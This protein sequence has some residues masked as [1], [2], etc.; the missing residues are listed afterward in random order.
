[1]GRYDMGVYGIKK[2]YIH[3]YYA[4]S[5]DERTLTEPLAMMRILSSDKNIGDW[6]W[7]K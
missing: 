5:D 4:S 2:I 3:E 6:L 1:M 7:Q